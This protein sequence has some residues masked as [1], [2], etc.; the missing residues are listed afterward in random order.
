MFASYTYNQPL[1]QEID[2]DGLAYPCTFEVHLQTLLQA[3][4]IFGGAGPA[5]L[6]KPKARRSNAYD[7][8]DDSQRGG[9][10]DSQAR[11]RRPQSKTPSDKKAPTTMRMSYAG[12]GEKLV[13]LCVVSSRRRY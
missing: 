4:D 13:L 12:D 3:M 6:P 8:D 1:G 10:D 9:G 7:D 2:E 11:F 5:V